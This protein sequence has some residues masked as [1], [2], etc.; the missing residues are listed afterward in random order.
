MDVGPPV[1]GVARD[2]TAGGLVV[3]R[4][5]GK[6][7]G[8]VEAYGLAL[9]SPMKQLPRGYLANSGLGPSADRQSSMAFARWRIETG[10]RICVC[11]WQRT[12]PA[13]MHCLLDTEYPSPVRHC[14]ALCVLLRRHRCSTPLAVKVFSFEISRIR[15]TRFDLECLR[16]TSS[17]RG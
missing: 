4:S 13:W 14:S 3:L 1:E 8:L 2:V 10:R 12:R 16:T 15:R 5:F 7:F 6:F 11:G 17:S 9:R